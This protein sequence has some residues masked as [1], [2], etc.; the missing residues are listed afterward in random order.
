MQQIDKKPV[1]LV[2][3]HE[4][5]EINRLKNHLQA[6][7]CVKPLVVNPAQLV[8]LADKSEFALILVDFTL[9]CFHLIAKVKAQTN[10]H[11]PVIALI[12]PALIEYKSQLIAAGFDDYL[13]KP[14]K[15][16]HLAE[17]FDL[18]Q[19]HPQ[20]AEAT[21]YTACVLKKAFGDQDLALTIFKKLFAELPGQL[22]AIQTALATE[23]Y[24]VA[25]DITHDINGSFGVCGL[26]DLQ[27]FA[28][29]LEKS[30]Q[31]NDLSNCQS[32]FLLMDEQIRRFCNLQTAIL[33]Y[34]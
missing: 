2:T 17:L 5:T 3:D 8:Q 24:S 33:A 23:Q 12:E 18:W 31:A 16:E 26:L 7:Y 27:Q 13:I 9:E 30:L 28:Q 25:E 29:Q 10:F 22:T 20:N 15:S 6:N 21:A 14:I 11:A 4:N 1:L 19:L 32:Y 34:F